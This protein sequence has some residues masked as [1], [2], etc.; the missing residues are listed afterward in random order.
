MKHLTAAD[1]RL[2]HQRQAQANR[3]I[4]QQKRDSQRG[5]NHLKVKL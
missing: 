3:H 5:K 1:K 2:I 4:L